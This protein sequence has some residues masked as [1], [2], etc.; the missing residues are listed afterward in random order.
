VSYRDC[1]VMNGS[2]AAGDGLGQC[3]YPAPSPE[4]E[5]EPQEVAKCTGQ[6]LGVCVNGERIDIDA[7]ALC[8]AAP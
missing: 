3:V 4:C 6:S 7:P 5:K 8:S 1:G 2:C